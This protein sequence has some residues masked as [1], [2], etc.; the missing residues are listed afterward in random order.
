MVDRIEADY[1][2]KSVGSGKAF[3]GIITDRIYEH[4]RIALL[5]IG[6]F[7]ADRERTAV[8]YRSLSAGFL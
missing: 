6:V 3:A 1:R 7:E 2:F 5:A 8:L 4:F